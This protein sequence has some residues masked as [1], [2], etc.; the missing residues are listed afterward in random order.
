MLRFSTCSQITDRGKAW[1]E[2]DDLQDARVRHFLYTHKNST[3]PDNED[4]EETE[5][6]SMGT[7]YT[8]ALSPMISGSKE[9]TTA[10]AL[11]RA[12]DNN[13][14]SMNILMRNSYII[15]GMLVTA[16]ILLLVVLL[17]VLFKKLAPHSGGTTRY[18]EIVPPVNEAEVFVGG[19][20]GRYSD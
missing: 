11:S 5:L 15:V 10:G 20:M 17:L 13:A 14:G 3:L 2:F 8:S 7:P 1:A 12:G 16:I 6:S 19:P 4:E 18:R 9:P